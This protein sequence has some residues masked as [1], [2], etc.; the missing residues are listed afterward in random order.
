MDYEEWDVQVVRCGGHW[1]IVLMS[2]AREMS[3]ER[4]EG[5]KEGYQHGRMIEKLRTLRVLESLA[6]PE[7]LLAEATCR[8]ELG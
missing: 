1:G 3:A 4:Y 6:L 2:E 8:L 7:D 5:Q